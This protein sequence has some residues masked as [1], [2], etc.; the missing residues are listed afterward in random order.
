[1][2][3]VEETIGK[4]PRRKCICTM[5]GFDEHLEGSIREYYFGF[6]LE[7]FCAE[8]GMGKIEAHEEFKKI[9]AELYG[10]EDGGD[11]HVFGYDSDLSQKKKEDFVRDVRSIMVHQCGIPTEAWKGVD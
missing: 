7:A 8:H 1:M 10:P 11:Y 4:M 2:Q 6:V 9:L 5:S 3:W